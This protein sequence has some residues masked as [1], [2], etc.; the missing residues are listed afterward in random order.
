MVR[1]NIDFSRVCMHCMY[2]WV[3]CI[4]CAVELWPLIHTHTHSHW[5]VF[6]RLFSHHMDILPHHSHHLL[7]LSVPF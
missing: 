6:L 7:Y 4:V 1:R 3:L 2:F 5:S